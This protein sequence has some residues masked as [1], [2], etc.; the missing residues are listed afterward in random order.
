M[1]GM[2][3]KAKRRC[4]KRKKDKNAENCETCGELERMNDKKKS[5]TSDEGG[6]QG[7]IC[8]RSLR[9]NVRVLREEEKERKKEKE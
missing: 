5:S 2:T 6:V 3:R 8:S 1:Q 7:S 4:V 9:A